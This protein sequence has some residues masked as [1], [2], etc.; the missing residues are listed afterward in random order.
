MPSHEWQPARQRLHTWLGTY[1]GPRAPRLRGRLWDSG[2]LEQ[3]SAPIA[4]PS[5][6]AVHM[7]LPGPH[8]MRTDF[9]R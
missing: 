1:V 2:A 8:D 9:I 3:W 6:R 5:M 4:T 7:G